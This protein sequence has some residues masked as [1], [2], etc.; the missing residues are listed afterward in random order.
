MDFH[1]DKCST[2]RISRSRKPITT[3]YTLKGHALVTEDSTKYLG[4]VLQP[5]LSWNRHIDQIAK[6]GNSMLGFLRRNL[7]VNNEVTKTAAYLSLVRPGLE[8]CFTVWSP[9]TQEAT[10]KLEMVQRRAARYVT[11]RYRN[12]SSV[13]SMLYHLQWKPI[14]SR[15]IKHRLAMM[16]KF[17]HA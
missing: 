16:F 15:S 3:S 17:L 12:T 6:K 1:P 11:N 7:K 5:N 2:L 8:Y 13:T 14:E 10:Q 9:H 4:V